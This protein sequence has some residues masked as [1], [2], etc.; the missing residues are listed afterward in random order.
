VL[1]LGGCVQTCVC[2]GGGGR[3]QVPG[4]SLDTHRRGVGRQLAMPPSAANA[5]KAERRKAAD[6]RSQAKGKL[7]IL[8]V[9]A[10]TATAAEAAAVERHRA[11][12]RH[13]KG[14]RKL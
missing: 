14:A 2:V 8:K 3:S 7:L 11:A 9:K 5:D 13:E 10:K 12:V 6:K 1:R 4:P